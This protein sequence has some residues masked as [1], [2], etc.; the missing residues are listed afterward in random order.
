[1]SDQPL[2]SY[3]AYSAAKGAVRSMTKALARDWGRYGITVN[4][5]WPNAGEA[6]QTGL[7]GNEAAA[8]GQ[9]VIDTTAMG[10]FGDPARDVAPVVAFLLSDDAGWVTGQTIAAN[11]GRTMV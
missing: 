1:M 7:V 6:I 5:M 8:W 10:R 11:G 9:A 3:V 2:P 4:T